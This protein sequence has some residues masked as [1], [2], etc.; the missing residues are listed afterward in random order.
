[1][2]VQELINPKSIVVVG[3]SQDI[4]KPGGK[5]LKNLID[6]KFKGDLYVSNPK[7]DEVQGIKSYKDLND[8]PQVDLAIIAIAAKYTLP[9]VTLLTEQKNTKA[10]IIISAG[11]SEESHEG[12]ILEENKC[13]RRHLD[14]AQLYRGAHCKSSRYFYRAYS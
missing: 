12:A 4:H 9:T 10:F 7:E 2:I 13:R 3:G 11:F 5:V 14:R 1:M 6:G 8:L